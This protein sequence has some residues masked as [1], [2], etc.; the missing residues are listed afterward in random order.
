MSA[1][2]SQQRETSNKVKDFLENLKP[3]DKIGI[4]TH[5]DTDGIVSALLFYRF[6]EKKGCKSISISI[7]TIGAGI[8]NN[9][10]HNA[11][12]LIIL[13]LAPNL[14][15]NILNSFSSKPILC[16]D[17]HQK[18]E[19]I[20]SNII[21]LRTIGAIP[22]SRTCYEILEGFVQEL[23]WLA[24][25]GVLADMGDKYPENFQFIRNFFEKN[26]LK[27][28]DYKRDFVYPIGKML[29]YF[30]DNLNKAFFILKDIKTKEDIKK[31][32]KYSIPVQNEI[33]KFLDL[34]QSNKE[35]IRGAI[36]FYFEPK[37]AIKSIIINMIS[38][39]VESEDSVLVFA[40][41]EDNLIRLSARCQSG[42]INVGELMKKLTEGLENATGG[43]HEKTA[44][45]AIMKKDLEVFKERLR[46][47]KL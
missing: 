14:V 22:T 20:P 31:I 7:L 21:E 17:H 37:F 33:D 41:P 36:F 35:E 12:K 24:M 25:S 27:I 30:E 9:D 2:R 47:L 5:D 6:L 32:I 15:I 1:I 11:D 28:Y 8:S 38:I 16:I 3:E 45:G 39:E 19:E 42:R 40:T 43:G 10:F 29:V 44:G 13:D 34:Y 18:Q 26:K 23:D 4:I 46:R